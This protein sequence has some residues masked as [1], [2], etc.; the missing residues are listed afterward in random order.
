MNIGII[1]SGSIGNYLCY[2]LGNNGHNVTF[3]D[4]RQKLM[5]RKIPA[6]I[7]K[8]STFV[9]LKYGGELGSQEDIV[10]V[11]TKSFDITPQLIDL[12]V[13]SKTEVIFLQN[14]L[15]TNLK[16][17]TGSHNFHF[18]TIYGIQAFFDPH[19]L[20]TVEASNCSIAVIPG[21]NQKHLEQ[22]SEQKLNNS[23]NLIISKNAS[24]LIYAKFARWIV[25]SAL[26]IVTKSNL[27]E[28]LKVI[29]QLEIRKLLED[30]E[31]ILFATVQYSLDINSVIEKI[32]SLPVDLVTSAY[33][34]SMDGTTNE[35]K[36]ELRFI[37][38]F[39]EKRGVDI[40]AIKEWHRKINES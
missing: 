2:S 7:S 3:Y 19:G 25:I 30:L 16:Y 40:L 5:D 10:F 11:T 6:N 27:G 35:L 14:G 28:S 38:L 39:M 33:R 31:T 29:S 34:D 9:E 8:I 12:L 32:Y 4:S 17:K 21:Q 13:G 37:I 15:V 18:G 23:P 1:G 36:E 20:L 22:L 26:N 24:D